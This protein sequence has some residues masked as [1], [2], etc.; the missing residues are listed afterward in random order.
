MNRRR[1]LATT[2]GSAALVGTGLPRAAFA[3]PSGRDLNF[4]FV[5]NTGGWDPTRVFA[6][7]FD[8]AAVDL[9]FDSQRGTAGNISFV[10]HAAR[11]SVRAF[12]DA[13]HERTLVLNGLMVRSI[14]HDMCRIISMTGGTSGFSPDWPAALAAARGTDFVLPHLVLGGP[15]YP[16]DLGSA[17]ARTGGGGQLGALLSGTISAWSDTPVRE[18]SSPES[19]VIDRYVLSRTR[20]YANAAHSAEKRALAERLDRAAT[21][22]VELKQYRHVMDFTTSE[23][24]EQQ[25]MVAVEALA[26]GTSRCVTMEYGDGSWDSH[27][28]NDATQSV[29]W[30]TL[31]GGLA[32]LLA[33]LCAEPGRVAV[34]LADETVVV[35]LSE[36]GRTPKL[37][38]K[39]GKDHWPF[40]SVMLVGPNIT[41][42]RVV[43]GF[44]DVY[45]GRDIDLG[46]G[47]L[48]DEGNLLSSEV[49]GA[50]LLALGDVDPG[51][52]VADADPILG[53]LG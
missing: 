22:A 38:G 27:V 48:T 4:V 43:G 23:D 41:G 6:T 51:T 49:L 33:L 44:D 21:D 7:A 47:E 25:A 8:N 17:V 39:N 32:Q 24:L 35:V 15:S 52:Y 13:Y 12:L 40:T 9:E 30:E 2:A 20:A 10:D 36:M 3:S 18:M 37:N 31:F 26:N 53:V 42:D 16:G 5:F 34:T 45:Y 14:A 29:M 11:P 19:D 1:F 46:S 50:T 28:D